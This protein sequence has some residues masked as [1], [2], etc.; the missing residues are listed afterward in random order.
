[1]S[2]LIMS[3]PL[4]RANKTRNKN[5]RGKIHNRLNME[6]F[7]SGNSINLLHKNVFNSEQSLTELLP[8][9]VF[10]ITI[11]EFTFGL[12]SAFPLNTEWH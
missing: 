5:N 10:V 2:H 8:L 9:K 7:I 4:P 12:L 6:L 1:M 11:Q 3:D